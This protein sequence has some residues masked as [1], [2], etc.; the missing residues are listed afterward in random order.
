MISS[1]HVPDPRDAF[2]DESFSGFYRER[3]VAMVRLAVM[4]VDQHELA[5]DIVQDAFVAVHR[6]RDQIV[7]ATS[8]L[9]TAVVNACRDEQRSRA[10]ARLRPE[11]RPP[12][13]AGET[14]YLRDLIRSLPARQRAA[15]VLRFYEDLPFDEVASALGSR[16][17]TAKSLVRRALI[18]LRKEIEP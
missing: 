8:Y 5:E 4:L 12:D 14:D 1:D 17:S 6:E 13:P 10:R 9:R 18:K 7:N 16:P 2:D 3:Y 15:L 11:P